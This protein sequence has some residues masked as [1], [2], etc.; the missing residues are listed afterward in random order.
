[1]DVVK[2][3]L[4]MDGVTGVKYRGILDCILTSARQ[5]GLQVFLKG[6]SLNSLRAFP[7]N[8]VTFLSYESILK[9]LC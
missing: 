4:Q 6:L 7:V 8:A 1:M 3:R 9:V 2:A 5:E